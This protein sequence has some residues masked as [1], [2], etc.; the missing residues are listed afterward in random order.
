MVTKSASLVTILVNLDVVAPV[1][2]NVMIVELMVII[3]IRRL[4]LVK[5][6]LTGN[7]A[8]ENVN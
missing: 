4:L 3:W 6:V 7:K 8:A 2:V 5:N 1:L